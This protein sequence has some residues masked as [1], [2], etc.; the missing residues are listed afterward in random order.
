MVMGAIVSRRF[1]VPG[2]VLWSI[3]LI[4]LKKGSMSCCSRIPAP[5]CGGPAVCSFVL[6]SV[7][8]LAAAVLILRPFFFYGRLR[9]MR[10]LYC[11]D[12]YSSMVLRYV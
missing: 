12:L 7:S 6:V 8:A 11:R 1:S 4:V 2:V 10:F 3:L 9:G 5:P